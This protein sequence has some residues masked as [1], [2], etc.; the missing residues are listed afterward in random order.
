MKLELNPHQ[1]YIFL[2]PLVK[3]NPMKN[4]LRERV[5]TCNFKCFVLDL[6]Y[7]KSFHSEVWNTMRFNVGS[8]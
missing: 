8:I 5:K 6:S 3:Y 2:A 4:K 7:F 1:K